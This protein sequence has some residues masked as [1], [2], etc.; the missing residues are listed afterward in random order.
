MNVTGRDGYAS[1]PSAG[2][3]A[4]TAAA[5]AAPPT[6]FRLSIFSSCGYLL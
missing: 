1:C 6:K 2:F 4:S 3:S 5:A